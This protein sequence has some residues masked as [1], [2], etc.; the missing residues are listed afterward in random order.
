MSR[1][2]RNSSTPLDIGR[3]ILGEKIYGFFV[4]TIAR[5]GVMAKILM[6]AANFNLSIVHITNSMPA[7]LGAP[8]SFIVFYDFSNTKVTPE[9]VK[10][11]ME[12]AVDNTQVEV[13]KPQLKGVIVDM[14]HHPLLFMGERAVIFRETVLKGWLVKI[15]E[16]F[17]TGGEAFLF[18]EGFEAGIAVYDSYSRM[19]FKGRG[20]WDM[21]SLVMLSAGFLSKM[22]VEMGLSIV[23]KVWDNI[24]CSMARGSGKCFSQWFRGLL[25]GFASRYLRKNVQVVETMCIAKGDPF[26]KFEIK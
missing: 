14:R 16:K 19:G 18:Y 1:P 17:G 15:R 23:V 11:A 24:E 13:I 4:K 21:L 26:C 2:D 10:E 6:V 7:R 22:K 25:A 5:R 20:L 3:I 9:E 12:R 8:A